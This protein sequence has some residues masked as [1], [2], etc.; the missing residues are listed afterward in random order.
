MKTN[1]I[2]LILSSSWVHFNI[3]T[4]SFYRAKLTLILTTWPCS[5]WVYKTFSLRTVFKN[6]SLII[7]H[8]SLSI[9]PLQ[10]P[11]SQTEQ[12]TMLFVWNTFI[13][14]AYKKKH[15]Y[16]GK[17][18][19]TQDPNSFISWWALRKQRLLSWKWTL[20][21]PRTQKKTNPKLNQ[22][23]LFKPENGLNTVSFNVISMLF[24]RSI[25]GKN[26]TSGL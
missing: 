4:Y 11:K 1:W 20:S 2:G 3:S 16:L 13:W 23:S 17:K 21:D 24:F 10:N 15:I 22:S 14:E 26:K 6:F 25:S 19:D 5:V 8:I 18:T 12:G 9:S 7:T